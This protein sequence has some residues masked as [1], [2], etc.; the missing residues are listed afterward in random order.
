MSFGPLVESAWL[1]DHLDDAVVVDCR[2]VLGRPG[3]GEAAWL[4]AHIPGAA[5]LDVDRDL[6]A[7]PGPRGRHPLPSAEA[8]E[9]AARRAGIRGD[10]R[11]VAYDEAGEGG[12]ARLWWL[13]R[14]FGHD[15]AAVLDGGL[16]AWREAG[17]KL[18]GGREQPE[19]GDFTARPRTDD[20][21]SAEEVAATASAAEAASTNDS[22]EDKASDGA[23][24]SLLLLDARAPERFRGENEPIDP[25]AGHIP[26]A[27]N[28]PTAS[29]APGGRFRSADELRRELGD[30]P[31]V[32]Y[33]G[34]GVTA[35]TLVLAGEIAGVKAKLY[36]GSWSEWVASGRPPA[37]S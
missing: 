35:C 36:P 31:F 10:S 25:I 3:G 17:G 26:G 37:R 20:T 2:F 34:S 29:V 4:E 19:A 30:Q 33:C 22:N 21:V 18:R 13:L 1:R 24:P 16:K 8:F 15:E 23:T 12:A 27:R 7:E 11:V 32:A 14:H 5:V 28:V 9:A 6:S